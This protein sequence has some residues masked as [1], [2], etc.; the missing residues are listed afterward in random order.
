MVSE[1]AK[2]KINEF[3]MVRDEIKIINPI[4]DHILEWKTMKIERLDGIN[5]V[6]FEV[7]FWYI[8]ILMNYDFYN[9]RLK[10]FAEQH[11]K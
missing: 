3:R 10:T 11:D 6:K 1:N 2:V 8:N 4:R 7:K 5:E 9:D